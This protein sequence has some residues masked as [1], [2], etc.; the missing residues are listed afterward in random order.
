MTVLETMSHKEP[1][2][3]EGFGF[4]KQA[5]PGISVGLG[6]IKSTDKDLTITGLNILGAPKWGLVNHNERETDFCS[7]WG[8]ILQ[9]SFLRR[10]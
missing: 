10:G 5:Y 1:F 3:T 4:G 6:Q 9:Q 7:I 2:K 8:S